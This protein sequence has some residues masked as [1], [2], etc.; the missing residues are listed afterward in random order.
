M[1]NETNPDVVIVTTWTDQN[2]Q[3]PELTEYSWGFASRYVLV[4]TEYDV[5]SARL[6]GKTKDKLFW[7]PTMIDEQIDD[8]IDWMDIPK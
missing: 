2:K 7:Y 5:T 4:R 8:V 1:T 3:I 6:E